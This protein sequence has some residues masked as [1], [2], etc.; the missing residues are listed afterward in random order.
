MFLFENVATYHC[1]ANNS[2]FEFVS[3]ALVKSSKRIGWTLLDE[4]EPDGR[5][6]E[7]FKLEVLLRISTGKTC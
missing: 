4:G 6:G 5:S 7:R 3:S 1:R 2:S